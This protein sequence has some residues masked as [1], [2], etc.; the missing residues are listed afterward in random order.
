M[1][2]SGENDGCHGMIVGCPV[3]YE[4]WVC[5]Y[6]DDLPESTESLSEFVACY[7]LRQHMGMGQ[8]MS[9]P[10]M[11]PYFVEKSHPLI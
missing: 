7:L 6:T 5:G 8:N 4:N 10:A 1:R 3:E 9:K 11:F 2:Y